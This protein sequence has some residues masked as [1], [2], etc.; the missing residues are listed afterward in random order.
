VEALA[1]Q[2]PERLK[3]KDLVFLAPGRFR[4]SPLAQ[5][6]F[7][8]SLIWRDPSLK[9]GK[10]KSFNVK[11]ALKYIN[12][13]IIRTREG[14]DQLLEAFLTV[15][16]IPEH[17]FNARL[18]HSHLMK[19]KLPKRDSWWLP[20][21][22][23]HYS[24]EG[25]INRLITWAWKGGGKSQVSDDAI[26]LAGTALAW[27]LTSSHRFLRDRATKA[28]VALLTDR[29]KVL[30]RILRRFNGVDDPYLTERLYAVAYGCSLRSQD[31]QALRGLARCVYDLVFKNGGPPVHIL[32]RDYAR[33]VIE[34][35]LY[36][37][38]KLEMVDQ[39]IR[40]PYKSTW[41]SR[42]MSEKKLKS[43]DRT[44]YGL[45]WNSLL[46]N[47]GGFPGD[48]GNYVVNSTLGHWTSFPLDTPRPPT[49]Q[50]I[51]D[52]FL[53]TLSPEQQKLW[54]K[55]GSTKG[56]LLIRMIQ[57]QSITQEEILAQEKEEDDSEEAFFE[58]LTEQQRKIYVESVKLYD[59]SN[60]TAPG[61]DYAAA[62]RWIFQRV[63]ELGWE[64]GSF[65]EFDSSISSWAREARKN[66]RIGKK[67]QWIAFHELLARV[68]DNFEFRKDRWSEGSSK[69]EGPW[70]LWIRDIDPSCLLERMGVED[71][72]GH[73]P[74]WF[75]VSY[76][77]WE[78]GL[79]DSEWIGKDDDIPKLSDLIEVTDGSGRGWLV[80]EGSFRWEESHPP[81]EEKYEK[82]RRD[83]WVMVKTYLVE[84]KDIE[85]AFNWATEQDFFGRWMP[86]SHPFINIFLR[87]FPWA[88]SY[89][90]SYGGER[91]TVETRSNERMPAKVLVTDEE[92]LQE[93]G[94]DCS[95]ESPICIKLPARWLHD[96]MQLCP[97]E[98][99]G[100]YS[101][102]RGL[103]V[104]FDPS[105]QEAGPGVLLV[106]KQTFIEFLSS[107]GYEVFWTVLGEKLVIGGG[108]GAG[109]WPGTLKIS[110]AYR[111]NSEGK[112]TG[113]FHTKFMSPAH[114]T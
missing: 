109:H 58:S 110:G 95:I 6:T 5:E 96:G 83:L 8:E 21:L 33:G 36:R 70:Q 68:A 75:S 37:G 79:S 54:E 4:G 89:L 30:A 51:Y 40:P 113:K 9:D 47:H 108:A 60:W 56:R 16:A 102:G 46:Y 71:K 14:H 7:I 18:L 85:N 92:Y 80:L 48:F 87:E 41:P 111:L 50:E 17:P 45:I 49:P 66:E 63:I 44:Q 11:S 99:D 67:Y 2:V 38:V 29:S 61:L 34:T 107:K 72:P 55:R 62:Q 24:E 12:G 53:K 93:R 3:G 77:A 26:D 98:V 90:A 106:D 15:A 28:L 94:F 74:W 91:W 105:V 103:K 1:I 86:E 59:K 20:F 73:Q 84:M 32:L 42:I 65:K 76:D 39:K 64:P 43:Y 97:T 22:Y 104:A 88:Q 81:E 27:F 25:V 31:G 101:D 52:A 69:Y 10:P 112:L 57:D 82:P 114:E 100:A 35:A 13:H 78:K 23:R 19:F